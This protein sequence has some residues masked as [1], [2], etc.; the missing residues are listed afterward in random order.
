MKIYYIKKFLIITI[1]TLLTI[2]L[3]LCKYSINNIFAFGDVSHPKITENAFN[4]ALEDEENCKLNKLSDEKMRF[5]K[6]YSIRPDYDENQHTYRYHFFNREEDDDD[7]DLYCLDNNKNAYSRMVH[8]YNKSIEFAKR[9]ENKESLEHLGRSLHFLQDMCCPVHIWGY[10]FNMTMYDSHSRLET[11]WDDM[12]E[13]KKIYSTIGES[14][15][16]CMIEHNDDSWRTVEDLAKHFNLETLEAYE[17]FI[18]CARSNPKKFLA[19]LTFL[20]QIPD[21]VKGLLSTKRINFHRQ[22]EP[23]W[24]FK[25]DWYYI[26]DIP[27]RASYELVRLWIKNLNDFRVNVEEILE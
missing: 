12:W 9:G 22:V 13:S 21:F 10:G 18:E 24:G 26:F 8:H 23:N 11:A 1:I 25:N 5:I 17:D 6:D 3:A 2:N 7:Y 16:R 19:G 20:H 4:A 14:H 15:V 27:Y